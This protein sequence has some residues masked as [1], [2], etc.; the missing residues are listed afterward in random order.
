MGSRRPYVQQKRAAGV[1]DLR[2]HVRASYGSF[3]KS[4]HD[5]VLRSRSGAEHFA[6]DGRFGIRNLYEHLVRSTTVRTIAFVDGRLTGAMKCRVVIVEPLR[7]R[8]R[9]RC[10][11]SFCATETRS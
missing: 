4:K 5:S 10:S 9:M 3:A 1:A 7:V 6:S 8:S 2:K 11:S